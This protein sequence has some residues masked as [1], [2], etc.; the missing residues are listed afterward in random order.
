MKIKNALLLICFLSFYQIAFSQGRKSYRQL[1]Q[2]K[3]TADSLYTSK[4]YL[5][6]LEKYEEAIKMT[7]DDRILLYNAACTAS[8]LGDMEKANDYLNQSIEKGYL[9]LDWL[10]KDKDF[11]NLR[12]TEYWDKH[13]NIL[14][15]KIQSI[16]SDFAE[17]KNIPLKNLIP[18]SRDGK[19]GY[20]NKENLEIIV[21]PN[22]LNAGFAGSCLKVGLTKKDFLNINESGNVEIY[23]PQFYNWGYPPASSIF[24]P[25]NNLKNNPKIDSIENFKGFR[26]NEDGKITEVSAIYEKKTE[27]INTVEEPVFL[28]I[29]IDQ[30]EDFDDGIITKVDIFGPFKI[31]GKWHAIVIKDKK[32]GVIDEEGNELKSLGFKYNFL[33]VE[34]KYNGDEV[35]FFFEDSSKK[36]GFIDSK[37]IIKLYVEFDYAKNISNDRPNYILLVKQYRY[38]GILD[39]SNLEW[40]VPTSQLKYININFT[41]EDNN[42]SSIH[43]HRK[44]VKKL[45]AYFLVE[46]KNGDYF[47]IGEDGVRYQPK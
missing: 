16:E 42:C 17:V 34:E 33:S 22:Y 2:L 1:Q 18:F 25:E 27:P 4:D 20:L 6:S 46:N 32:Y 40:I 41:T 15:K 37:G 10:S 19:W 38:F 3:K 26:V 11:D 28:D 45:D 14:K 29:D 8:L 24:Y 47:Y 23:K 13:I 43:D 44:R 12:K 9:D 5:K 30:D 7:S 31:K 36:T 21:P 39:L 35:L